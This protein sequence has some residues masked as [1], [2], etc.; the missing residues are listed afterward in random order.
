MCYDFKTNLDLVDD[1]AA[2]GKRDLSTDFC[3]LDIFLD[4]VKYLQY[5]LVRKVYFYAEVCILFC[6]YVLNERHSMT[7]FNI[8]QTLPVLLVFFCGFYSQ[9]NI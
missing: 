2:G 1:G 9:K 5:F 6:Y 8:Q 3:R 4:F 7:T